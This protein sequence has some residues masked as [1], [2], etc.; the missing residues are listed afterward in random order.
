MKI[1]AAVLLLP[2]LALAPA[3]GAA[4]RPFTAHD[5]VALERVSRP[6]LSPDGRHVAYQMR[7]TDLAANK[8]VTGIWALDLARK[9]ARPRPLTAAGTDSSAPRAERK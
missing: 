7:Q 8:G 5:L 6:K 3:A 4:T 9:G 2:A 1:P